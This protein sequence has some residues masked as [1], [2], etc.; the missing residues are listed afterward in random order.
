MLPSLVAD[1]KNKKKS[2]K[3][4]KK[5]SIYNN[6]LIQTKITDKILINDKRT[7][8]KRVR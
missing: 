4:K 7:E 3:N 2:S 5:S 1:G 6:S 8:Q